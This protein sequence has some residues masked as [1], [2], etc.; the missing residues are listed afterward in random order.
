MSNES[1]RAVDERDQVVVH[2]MEVQALQIGNIARNVD[3]KDLA[4]PARGRLGAKCEPLD[5]KARLTWPITLPDDEL[6]VRQ[7]LH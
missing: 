3:R 6:V 2:H 5:D 1:E 4:A 7:M